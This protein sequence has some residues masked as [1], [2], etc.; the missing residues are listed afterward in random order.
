MKNVLI[1]TAALVGLTHSS[2]GASQVLC[3]AHCGSAD[4]TN[5][6][7]INLVMA[8]GADE[9]TA[10]ANLQGKCKQTLMNGT[11]SNVGGELIHT[12]TGQP[13]VIDAVWMEA[14]GVAAT[15]ANSCIPL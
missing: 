14:A 6:L 5:G 11:H 12:P 8:T 15:V 9:S 4:T 1:I 13:D 10:F 2:Y 7:S 3:V